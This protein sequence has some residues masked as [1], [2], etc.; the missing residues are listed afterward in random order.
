[1]PTG[2]VERLRNELLTC[3]FFS[4][5]AYVS[6]L[7]WLDRNDVVFNNESK[8]VEVL[9][10]NA[11][12]LVKEQMM[13][14]EVNT[15]LDQLRLL[16][17]WGIEPSILPPRTPRLVSWKLPL[18]GWIKINVDGSRKDDGPKA[19]AGFVA[20]NSNSDH[21]CSRNF[22]SGLRDQS[23]GAYCSMEGYCLVLQQVQL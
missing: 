14:I 12:L 17:D 5:I 19:G 6:W 13:N 7:I 18:P 2:Y 22:T 23:G 16:C 15:G 10:E 1:M 4:W 8:L 21:H 3:D 9:F 11:H 20:R